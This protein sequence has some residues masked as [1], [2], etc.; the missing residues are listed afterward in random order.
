MQNE[1]SKSI[2]DFLQSRYVSGFC[3]C[4]CNSQRTVTGLLSL[5]VSVYVALL[6]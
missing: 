2:T 4:V 1:L 3:F 6:A 5:P